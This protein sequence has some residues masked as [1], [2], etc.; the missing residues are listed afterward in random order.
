MAIIYDIEV[1]PNCFLLNAKDSVNGYMESFEISPWRNDAGK[2]VVACR[3]FA[4]LKQ[5]M[6]GFNNVGYDYP[7]LHMILAAGV[8]DYKLLY[9][10]SYAIFNCA[11]RFTHVVWPS[12]RLVPQVDLFKIHHF[13]NKAKMTGLKTLEFNMRMENISDLPILPG[14][15]LTRE[16]IEVLRTYCWND[17]AATEKFYNESLEQIRFR[18][19]LTE[20]YGFDFTNFSDVK[21]GREIFIKTLEAAGIQCYSYGPEG[22]QPKQT[23]RSSIRLADCVPSFINFQLPEFQA[24]HRAFLEKTIEKTKNAFDWKA[25]VDGLEFKFGTGGIHASV[26]N[27][28]FESNDK[29]MIYDIDVTSLYPSIAIEHGYYPEH[30]GPGFVKVYREMRERRLQYKKGTPENATLKLSLNGVYGSSNEPFGVFFDPLFTMNITIGGQLMIA[31]L[32]ERLLMSVLGLR[33]IQANTDGITMYIPRTAKATVDHVCAKWE[34][35]TK[36]KLECKEFRIMAVADVNSYLAVDTKGEVKRIGRY[37]YKIE[38]HQDG[39]ALVVPK[40]AEKAL[41]ENIRDRKTIME[42]IRGWPDIMDFMLRIKANKGTELHLDMGAFTVPI[43]DKTQRYYVSE[44]GGKLFKLM[45][46]KKS[47]WGLK[48]IGVQAGQTVC[49]C[50]NIQDA[51]LKINYDWYANEVHKLVLRIQ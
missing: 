8:D 38:W 20:Q 21:I 13:D 11:D 4:H 12:Q 34:L 22:R 32:V 7:V 40:V 30:L 49:P 36:L 39:S 10:K 15:V 50:N 27:L 48:W 25:K 23:H 26:D 31:M 16:Q 35:L 44:G 1:Y 18:D 3:A 9:Q 43:T 2:I 24:I 51:Q 46:D 37:E 45:P 17:V 42:I 33:I 6:V 19:Q 5:R 14:T 47:N 28:F 41:T 29:W